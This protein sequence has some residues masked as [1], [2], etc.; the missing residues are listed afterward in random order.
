M[1]NRAQAID[2]RL[3]QLVHGMW[4]VG[5]VTAISSD[6]PPVLTVDVNGATI[7]MYK[8]DSYTATVG[9]VVQIA[10]PPGRPFVLGT[11]G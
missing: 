2:Q 5:T 7:D 6:T 3:D 4:A 10:W 11:I 8:L 9:D 1:T